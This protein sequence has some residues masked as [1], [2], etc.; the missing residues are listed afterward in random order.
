M[1]IVSPAAFASRLGKP[2]SASIKRG[3]EKE[4]LRLETSG[5]L[6]MHAHPQALGSTLTHRFITTDYSE[7]LLEFITPVGDSAD[8][9][10]QV[11]DDVHRFTY[12]NIGEEL[13]WPA[14]MPCILPG[15]ENIPI[16]RYGSSNIGQLKEVYRIGLGNRYGRLMQ[17]IAGIHYN[18]SVDDDF[19]NTLI[20]AADYN[21]D[22]QTF[23]NQK[24]LGLIRN[25]RRYSWLLIYLFGASPAVCK[26]FLGQRDHHL[27]PI[28]NGTFGL[29]HGTSLRMGDLGYQSSAQENLSVCYN[30]LDRYCDNLVAAIKQ[31]I[32]AY[33]KIG[34]RDSEGNFLQL[35]ESLLQIENEFYSTIRP[36]R[37]TASGETPTA[38]LRRGGIEYIEVRCIDV[39]PYLPLGIDATMIHFID[40]FLLYCLFQDSP[41]CDEREYQS[42]A[43]NRRTIVNQGRAPDA[44]LTDS[45][46]QYR[47][48]AVSTWASEMLEAI[49]TLADQLGIKDSALQRAIY[50]QRCKVEDPECT[51][52]ARIISDI[53]RQDISYFRFAM[54][55]AEAHAE[56]FRQTPL[57]ADKDAFFRT[58]ASESM[59]RQ[60]TLEAADSECFA[61]F[62]ARYYRDNY[63]LNVAQ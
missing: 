37:T 31:P 22:R 34:T 11:L 56:Q 18:F 24:Y 50:E 44:T 51:P 45:T 23:I 57:P 63:G 32:E 53:K 48:V 39:N 42:F 25:F 41:D 4:A 16:A 3:I 5:L 47:Q 33:Q 36:K 10:L 61:D 1:T 15:D 46:Q 28:D 2:I 55:M 20:E 60:K 58:E 35:N 9:V 54:N 52:S 14:S 27:S 19:W 38:A 13:L 8:E 30:N 29:L 62:W 49:E 59:Q 7:A 6:S 17:T 21:G 40:A 26:S 12:A 43:D